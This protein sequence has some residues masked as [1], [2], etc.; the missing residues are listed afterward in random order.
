MITLKEA[1][2]K[3]CTAHRGEKRCQHVEIK[4]ANAVAKVFY[5]ACNRRIA[6]LS[7][8]HRGKI[9]KLDNSLVVPGSQ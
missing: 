2:R 7:I 6:Y 9:Q 4:S 3:S 1:R 5:M 8:N